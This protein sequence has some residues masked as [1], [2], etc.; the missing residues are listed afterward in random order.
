MKSLEN[1]PQQENM[2][3]ELQNAM[4]AFFKGFEFEEELKKLPPL[5]ESLKIELVNLANFST[6]ARSGVIRD[7]GMKKDVIFVPAA[8]MPTRFTQQLSCLAT[9][10]MLA[11][12]GPLTD[13]DMKILYKVALDSIPQTNKMVMNEMARADN[14]TTAEIATALGYPTEPIKIYLENLA[15]LKVCRR[16]KDSGRAD[17]WTMNEEFSDIVRNYEHIEQLT[18]EEIRLRKEDAAAEVE[19][20]NAPSDGWD[21][22]TDLPVQ[23]T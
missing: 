13:M 18:D 16:I 5:E 11:N 17:R 4:Y 8:E 6:M 14:Q 2:A 21:S 7:F 23:T 12:K 10:C 15:L 1:D 20:A 9:G 19:D 22:F 3:R